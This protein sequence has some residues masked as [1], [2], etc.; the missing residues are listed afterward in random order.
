[1][2]MWAA[3]AVMCG[4]VGTPLDLPRHKRMEARHALG[5]EVRGWKLVTTIASNPSGGRRSGR[6]QAVLSRTRLG[7]WCGDSLARTHGHGDVPASGGRCYLRVRRGWQ[8]L[9]W[10]RDGGAVV[11]PAEQ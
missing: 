2:A 1:M 8:G 6:T 9:R 4:L 11:A 3:S 7:G 5:P 10:R